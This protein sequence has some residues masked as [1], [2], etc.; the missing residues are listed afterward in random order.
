MP[1]LII[2]GDSIIKGVCFDGQRYHL[3]AGHGLE[4]LA[5]KG[6]TVQNFAKMGA[7]SAQG[8]QLL[9]KKL[10]ACGGQTTVLFCFGGNDC[11]YDWQA[12]S[13]A[14]EQTHLPHVVP[15]QFVR[16]YEA[17]LVRARQHGARAAALL[18]PPIHAG[19]FFCAHYR[20]KGRRGDPALAGRPGPSFALAGVLQQPCG[21]DGAEARLPGAR[22]AQRVS[23]EPQL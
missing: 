14:P 21:A 20:R 5:A 10:G 7:T 19:R 1:E 9:E 12:I 13:D 4:A 11:D 17:L 22:C 23:E 2:F 16:N 18:L 6:V 8:L 3:C 15:E